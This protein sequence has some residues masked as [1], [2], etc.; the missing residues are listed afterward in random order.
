[1]APARNVK[2]AVRRDA[3]VACVALA[4][5]LAFFGWIIFGGKLIVGGDA[6]VESHPLRAVFWNALA[7]GELQLWTPLIFSGYPLLSIAQLGVG[8][9]LTWV[10]LVLP[11]HVAEEVYVL[12]PFLLAPIFTYAYA[13]ELGLS[14]L[15]SLFAGL[16]FGYGGMTTIANGVIGLPTNGLMWLPLVLV[17]CER[18]RGEGKF[19]RC[20]LGATAAFGMSVL[21]GHGQSFVYVGAAAFAYALFLSFA[22]RANVDE[23]AAVERRRWRTRLRPLAVCFGAFALSAGLAAFQILETMRAVR[24]SVRSALSYE[25]FT[26]GSFTL[27][28][29][30]LSFLAPL[31]N[32]IDVTAYVSPLALLLALL[33]VACA[34]RRRCGDARVYFW[35]GVALL[36]FV[37]MLG[38]NT[39]FYR[40]VY[41][42]PLLNRFR[43]PSRHAFEWTFALSLL[44]AYG[45]DVAARLLSA[46]GEQRTRRTLFAAVALA[47]LT[48]FAGAYWFWSAAPVA[49]THGLTKL[50]TLAESNYVAL[51]LVFSLLT[52]LLLWR[53][54]R[55]AG[56]VWR[57]ALLLFVVLLVSFVEPHLIVKRW[58][59]YF[60]KPAE[61][62]ARVAPVTQ[63]LVQSPPQEG[64]VYTRFGLYRD[65]FMLGSPFDAQ[66]RT[67][68]YG[69]HN[70]AGY[71]PLILERYSRALGNVSFDGVTARTGSPDNPALLSERSHVLDLLNARLLVAFTDF[72]TVPERAA[73]G[74][75]APDV[76]SS[77]RWEQVHAEGR[78]AV[79]RNTRALPRAWLVAE[80]QA[81]DGEVALRRIQGVDATDFD[82]RRTA[83]LE[84]APAELPALAGGELAEGSGASVVSYG[85][86]RI[87]VE[88]RADKPTVLV[89]SE[90]FYPGWEATVDGKPAPIHLADFLLRGVY[91]EAGTHRVEMRYNSPALRYGAMLSAF[92]LLLLG[93]LGVLAFR[94][95]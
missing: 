92:T 9:P 7:R 4:F 31:Y 50:T 32:Y 68:L 26:E 67:A 43:V 79:L 28:Q 63:F 71:D 62:F 37:L 27:K 1:M 78:V 5:F 91:L 52:V 19:S 84:V 11:S 18:A 21:N 94:A 45:W 90:I 42:V 87:A 65:E 76:L 35:S 74:V 20:L 33:A 53:A 44:G 8:Y 70:V 12:A 85:A 60:V 48:T 34:L 2:N 15:A 51:K 69:L 80:A 41:H 6:F 55:V 3:G 14:R 88:T 89:V 56:E 83:L 16:S 64:R 75:A 24:R 49:D 82:P 29:A 30:C 54:W 23:Q 61:R 81:V 93:A 13:R 47:L 25:T 86:N 17:A 10:Y 57:K 46:H 38:S 66:N 72:S 77:G 39:P 73:I 95:R 22:P 36:S 59:P 40:L 58:W